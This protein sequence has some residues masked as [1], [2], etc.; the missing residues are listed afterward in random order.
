[1]GIC[2]KMRRLDFFS[3]FPSTSLVAVIHEVWSFIKTCGASKWYSCFPSSC[4]LEFPD[5]PSSML[6]L[7]RGILEGESNLGFPP[8]QILS[9]KRRSRS[10]NFLCF[11]NIGRKNSSYFLKSGALPALFSGQG[12]RRIKGENAVRSDPRP[13]TFDEVSAT[14]NCSQAW[15]PLSCNLLSAQEVSLWRREKPL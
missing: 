13:E 2:F 12:W 15:K 4:C 7:T 14:A 9:A 3:W 6:W 11:G 1:M 10:V 5:D 8:L